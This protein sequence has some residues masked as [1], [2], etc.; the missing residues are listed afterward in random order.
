MV[1]LG[2][3]PDKKSKIYNLLCKVDQ[4]AVHSTIESRFQRSFSSFSGRRMKQKKHQREMYWNLL[5]EIWL[6]IGDIRLR[7][8]FFC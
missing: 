3:Y 2:R 1:L 7:L 8:V 4:A 6:K 5:F